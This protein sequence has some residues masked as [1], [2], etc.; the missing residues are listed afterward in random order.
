[1]EQSRGTTARQPALLQQP[2]ELDWGECGSESESWSTN[3]CDESI[4]EHFVATQ[5]IESN[6]KPF[7]NIVLNF[8]QFH[9]ILDSD[10]DE[11]YDHAKIDVWQKYTHHMTMFN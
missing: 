5:D 7:L 4:V 9:P 8:D 2:S 6:I 11:N 1:M 10:I 3:H